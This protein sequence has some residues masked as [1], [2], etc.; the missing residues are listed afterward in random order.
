MSKTLMAI[1]GHVGDAELTAGLILATEALKGSKIVTV[2][3]TGGERGAP[4]GV[5]ISEY[6]KQ[7][8]NEAKKFADLLGGEAI[9]FPIADCELTEDQAIVY[10]VA[11]LI[12]KY[13][14]NYIFTHWRNSMHK[15]HV[16]THRIV[17]E[18][19][20]IAALDMGDKLDGEPIYAPV[21]FPE[22]WE[23]A[24]DF[25]PYI[26]VKCSEAGY[27][28]WKKGLQE[29]WFVMHSKDFRYY[30]Y[31]THLAVVRGCLAKSKYGVALNILPHQK[32]ERWDFSE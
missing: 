26:Y 18:A 32:F 25:K 10:Q 21:Y 1:G 16:K 22:N 5:D 13:R 28:L 30:D 17:M 23:D 9:V 6:R 15:D 3:L 14:P 27:E 20:L 7:K 2:A 24:E 29:H 19:Q 12:R 4:Q 8:E 11:A 31:Y